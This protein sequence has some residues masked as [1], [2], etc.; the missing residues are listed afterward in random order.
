MAI[1]SMRELLND[2]RRGGYAVG[3]FSVANMECIE[4]VLKAAESCRAPIILQIAEVR[5]PYSPL[6]LIGPMM[7][8]AAGHASVPVA[9]HLDHGK[10]MDCFREAL[11]LGFT[12][13]MCDAS[14]LPIEENVEFTSRVV[15]LAK[16]YGAVV[17]AEVGRVGKGEDGEAAE[18][19]IASLDDCRKMDATGITALAVGIGNAH[20]LYQAIP[21]L[22]YE[23]LEAMQGEIQ[24]YP[25]LHGGSGLT[26]EQFRRVIEL[27]MC[28]INIATDIF[29]AQA[30]HCRSDSIF[31]NIRASEDAV[32]DVV[33]RY[34][35]L[36]G[37]DG[38]I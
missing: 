23:V 5:L 20:G 28:K 34:I 11:D 21:K 12:S 18:E 27:G 30:R 13:I 32:C 2:A 26:D 10:T 4:G 15:E 7:L 37:S 36:F 6:H 33:S 8:A 22:H 31:E 19:V 29:R 1:V 3:S 16:P 38:K 17:E 24:A 25:V 14:Q 35:H 9:V